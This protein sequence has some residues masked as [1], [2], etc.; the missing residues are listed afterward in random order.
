MKEFIDGLTDEDAAEGRDDSFRVIFAQEGKRGRVLLALD[1]FVKK[2]RKTP[3]RLIQ[4]AERRLADWRS[5]G[6]S[7]KSP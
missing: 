1:G 7:G 2:T 3:P 5:R 6:Q 4:L